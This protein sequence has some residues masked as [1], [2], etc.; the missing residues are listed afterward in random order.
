MNTY[1]LAEILHDK[2]CTWN[3]I[4]ACTWMYENDPKYP[5]IKWQSWAH[6]KFLDKAEELI[7]RTGLE[8]EDI[9]R[10]VKAL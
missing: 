10:V 5:H 3:H 4:D 6:K 9:A 2:L 1:V 7:K 8:P